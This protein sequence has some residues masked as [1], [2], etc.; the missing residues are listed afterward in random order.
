MKVR[1]IALAIAFLAVACERP[2]EITLRGNNPPTFEISGSG[3]LVFL[4]IEA[5]KPT[6]EAAGPLGDIVWEIRPEA[7][8]SNAKSVEQLKAINYGRVP[9]GYVQAYPEHGEALP[10]LNDEKYR[11]W[12]DTLNARGAIL[13]FMIQDGKAVEAKER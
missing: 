1:L 13:Y 12:I 7:E 5:M 9:S 10:L 4:R 2:T 8:R 11:I 3:S 6:S